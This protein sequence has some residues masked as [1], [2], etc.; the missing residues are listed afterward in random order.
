MIKKYLKLKEWEKIILNSELNF[1]L[2][3]N[4]KNQTAM[5]DKI[6]IEQD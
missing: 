3:D 6:S 5:F 2:L 4:K 1:I